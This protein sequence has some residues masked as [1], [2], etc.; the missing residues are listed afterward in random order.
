MEMCLEILKLPEDAFANALKQASTVE[1][2]SKIQHL[3]VLITTSFKEGRPLYHPLQIGAEV[4]QSMCELQIV[5]IEELTRRQARKEPGFSPESVCAALKPLVM[6][7]AATMVTA[8]VGKCGKY[9]KPGKPWCVFKHDGNDHSK[10]AATQPKGWPK[11]YA[12]EEEAKKAIKMMHTF[13]T[14]AKVVVDD[15]MQSRRYNR[16]LYSRLVEALKPIAKQHGVE[17]SISMS[18][19]YQT[20]YIKVTKE[21]DEAFNLD[22]ESEIEEALDSVGFTMEEVEDKGDDRYLVHFKD[23]D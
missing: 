3:E 5:L 10:R 8:I 6:T 18:A 4:T 13:G 23:L 9:A 12:T 19:K 2:I 22:F 11:H 17:M 16:K 1:I 21:D 14:T 7:T 15:Y 20:P